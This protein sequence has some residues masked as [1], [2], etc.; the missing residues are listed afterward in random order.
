MKIRSLASASLAATCLAP[1][2]AMSVAIAQPAPQ[3]STTYQ[4]KVGQEGK[5]VVWVPSPQALVDRMLDMAKVTKDDFVIDLGSGDGRTVI[6]AAR[7]GA[8][9]LGIE[10]NPDLVVL[11]KENA[12]KEGVTN[13][14]FVQGD[15]FETDFTKATVLTLFLLPQLNLKLRPTILDMKPGTRVVSNTFNMSEWEAD[16][17]IEAGGD[18]TSYCR[19]FF[20][21][22]P[23][24][25]AGTWK[26]PQG[27]LKLDQSF[28]K[29]SGT[30]TADGKAMPISDAKMNGAEI[31]FTA[32]GKTYSGRVD[33]NTMEGTSDGGWKA[34]RSGA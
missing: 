34:T 18:C 1:L 24:K 27:E 4:P 3:T 5:D 8:R 26:M 25:V 7:R 11:S 17:S 6:T 31:T 15:I 30:L 2:L 14:E 29:L 10:Y 28:Q 32:G 22:V 19:A 20:W 12:K 9:A 13:A 23:A 21:V 16:Q 33:G